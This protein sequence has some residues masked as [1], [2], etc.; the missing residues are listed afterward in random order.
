MTCS[1]GCATSPSRPERESNPH[2]AHG[3]EPI[4]DHTRGKPN[5]QGLGTSGQ[6]GNRTR[7]PACTASS[8]HCPLA[9]SPRIATARNGTAAPPGTKGTP[10]VKRRNAKPTGILL[11]PKNIPTC[12]SILT[13]GVATT[14][15]AKTLP[16]PLAFQRKQPIR[17]FP[18]NAGNSIHG[19]NQRH[20]GPGSD[21]RGHPPRPRCLL[22]MQRW[23]MCSIVVWCIERLFDCGLAC[24]VVFA[25][26]RSYLCAI[27]LTSCLAVVPNACR[28]LATVAIVVPGWATSLTSRSHVFYYVF[29]VAV[30]WLRH[31]E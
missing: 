29:C 18:K 19:L 8:S 14:L 26:V 27:A 22:Y 4:K 17:V 9:A 23:Y 21:A 13:N 28:A 5:P 16:K 3:G 30:R 24:R 25:R 10:P 6:L 11:N 1:G 2:H 20:S 15:Q 12:A 31:A 7:R